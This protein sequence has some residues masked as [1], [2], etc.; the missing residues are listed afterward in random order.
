MGFQGRFSSAKGVSGR[1]IP[2]HP[3]FLFLLQ[4]FF[5]PLLTKLC[6]RGCCVSPS[7][8]EPVDFPIVQYADDTLL[9]LEACPSQL[10]TLKQILTTFAS[11]TGLKVNYDKS[12]MLPINIS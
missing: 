9:I 8:K 4:I 5:N 11:A 3:C 10:L 6:S 2:F 1:V 7:L 12:I